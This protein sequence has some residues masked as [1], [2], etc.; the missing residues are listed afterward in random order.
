[1][2]YLDSHF[3]SM[4]ATIMR[5]PSSLAGRLF[6]PTASLLVIT[7][8]LIPSLARINLEGTQGEVREIKKPVEREIATGQTHVYTIRLDVGQYLYIVA[9]QR[10]ADVVLTLLAPGGNRLVEVDSNRGP[11][12]ADA[13]RWI[14]EERGGHRIEV[15]PKEPDARAG[16]Y[17]IRVAE[18]RTARDEDRNRVRAQSLFAEALRLQNQDKAEARRESLKKFEESLS[19]WQATGERGEEAQ[20]LVAISEVSGFLGDNKKAVACLK[21]ALAIFREL[22]DIAG[23]A[24]A[25]NNLGDALNSTDDPKAAL[26]HFTL[27]L[28]FSRKLGNRQWEASTLNHIGATYE[29]LSDKKKALEYCLQSLAIHREISNRQ[30]E[31]STLNVIGTIYE[32]LGENA[33]AE[34][35]YQQA[36]T[37]W[38]ELGNKTRQAR[39]LNNLGVLAYYQGEYDKALIYYNQALPVHR[40]SGNRIGEA[41]LLANIAL[42]YLDRREGEKAVENLKL[43]LEIYR[44]AGDLGG[45][46]SALNSLGGFYYDKNDQQTAIKYFEQSLEVARRAND[47]RGIALA[48][49]NNSRA[50]EKSGDTR[51]AL[52]YLR[53]AL[54]MREKLNDRPGIASTLTFMGDLLAHTGERE[55]SLR[56]YNRAL[57]IRRDLK[58]ARGE[59]SMLNRIGVVYADLGD[60]DRALSYYEEA[61]ALGRSKNDRLLEAAVLTNIGVRHM[62]HGDHQKALEFFNQALPIR[63]AIKD[64]Q[65]EARTLGNIA[66]VY[67]NMGDRPKAIDYLIQTL[68]ISREVGDRQAEA[69]ALAYLGD[70][71][72]KAGEK[73]KAMDHYKESLAIS[74]A[75]EDRRVQANVLLSIAQMERDGGD[76]ASARARLEE[77]LSIIEYMRIRAPGEHFRASYFATVNNHFKTYIDV[78]MQLHKREPDAGHNL[79]ALEV[80]ERGRAR[81]LLDILSDARA[82]TRRGVPQEL[83]ERER[84][85]QQELND[86]AESQTRLLSGKRPNE[87]AARARK[88]IEKLIEQ[89]RLLEAQIRAASPRA[90]A[91]AQTLDARA[92]G[93]SLDPD[94]LLLEYAL[95][96]KRSY[97]WAVS[98][99]RISAFDLPGRD[100]IEKLSRRFYG[101]LTARQGQIEGETD[102]VKIAALRRERADKADAELPAAADEL[103]RMVIGP[104]SHLLGKKRLVIVAEGALQ[105][106]PFGA[107]TVPGGIGAKPITTRQAQGKRQGAT[108]NY[109]PLIEDHEIIMLPSASTLSALR[110]EKPARAPL[111]VAVFADPVFDSK[112][113]RVASAQGGDEKKSDLRKSDD[114]GAKGEIDYLDLSTRQMTRQGRKFA[115]LLFSRE[116]AEAIATVDPSAMKALD[117]RASR[118]TALNSNLSRYR[119]VHFA[120]HGLVNDQHPELSGVVLSLVDE[121]GQKQ[122]GFLRLNEIYGLRLEADLVL[123]SACE[124]GVGKAVMG[125]GLMSLTRGFM[126]AGATKVVASL[127]N[128]N[129]RATAE[130]MRLFYEAMLKKGMK[131]SSALRFA[132]IELSRQKR[133]RSPYYWAAFA[134]HGDWR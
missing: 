41:N 16:R 48:L 80:A 126:H 92:I 112:D 12:G 130:L 105:Y 3:E 17:E 26:E 106:V 8:A 81:A 63:R 121:R 128:V 104:V 114:A 52:K 25:H 84:E 4:E 60:E 69:S 95:G 32:S 11:N 97:L 111:S 127:W 20:T 93:Q 36:L 42:V 30:G 49:S 62:I 98:S 100:E 56:A 77:S 44:Q 29:Q 74:R 61:L 115:R 86:K 109:H 117:F 39:A 96:E 34:E 70:Q 88:E 19:L 108:D 27:S 24:T 10:G 58:N 120:T 118:D 7:L 85:I 78:L 2:S 101:L 116:E 43:A 33:K 133:W 53:D 21:S 102:E 67:A 47:P 83:L 75:I 5:Y 54:P 28:E 64:R 37:I 45:E 22:G 57:E 124:T 87:E 91:L 134:L 107:M 125:E 31:A 50:Y 38:K 89:Y 40:Q 68:P 1:L 73:A 72:A 14:T 76:L 131:A 110:R 123:L 15:R 122:N 82:D 65:G 6:R 71:F 129:D 79:V 9:D 94:T 23:Q 90:A 18:L 59:A 51:L 35:H 55:E 132:Q 113:S 103:S 99:E 13:L 66:R 119:V 46:A